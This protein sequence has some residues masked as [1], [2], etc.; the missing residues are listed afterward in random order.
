[1]FLAAWAASGV[2]AL[3]VAVALDWRWTTDRALVALAPWTPACSAAL[4]LVLLLAPA[5]VAGPF[6]RLGA[7]DASGNRLYRAYFIADFVWHTALT[8]ELTRHEQP[9]RNPFLFSKPIHYYWT[10]FVVPATLAAV[11]RSDVQDA[12]KL[13][14]V[15]ASLL[16]VAAIYLA[17]WAS[18]PGRP[19]AVATAVALT[20]VAGSA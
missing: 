5:L 3:A 15:V 8:A 17:A 20:I 4:A 18:V 11:T 14:A 2:L 1:P 7:R 19:F 13:N 9:P 10:Y 6:A 16:F 12:L